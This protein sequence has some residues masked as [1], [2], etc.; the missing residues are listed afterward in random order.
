MNLC[1]SDSVL[2]F[3]HVIVIAVVCAYVIVYMFV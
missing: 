1:F 3:T 2:V